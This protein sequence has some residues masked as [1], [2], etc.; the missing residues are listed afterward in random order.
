MWRE[1]VYSNI[2]TRD[3]AFGLRAADRPIYGIDDEFDLLEGV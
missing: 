1:D 2:Q 3:S